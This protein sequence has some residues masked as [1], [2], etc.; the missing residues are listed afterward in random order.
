MVAGCAEIAL[1]LGHLPIFCGRFQAAVVFA[2]KADEF[3]LMLRTEVRRFREFQLQTWLCPFLSKIAVVTEAM[4]E[5]QG[6]SLVTER[7]FSFRFLT[8]PRFDFFHDIVYKSHKIWVQ[9]QCIFCNCTFPVVSP[10]RLR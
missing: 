8:Q 1:A 9:Y 10:S 6:T 3:A 2:H 5:T 7:S 4:L